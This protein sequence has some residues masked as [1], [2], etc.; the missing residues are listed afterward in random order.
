MSP[1]PKP[2]PRTETV[3]EKTLEQLE[4]I[5]AST[6]KSFDTLAKP[7]RKRVL[8]RYPT[9]FLFLVTFGVVATLLGLEQMLLRYDVFVDRPE[10]LFITGVLV[11]AFTGT[12]YKKLG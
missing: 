11:L 8:K 10:L 3:T 7:I 2:E 9:V 6:Q 4:T 12:L 5:T 1:K